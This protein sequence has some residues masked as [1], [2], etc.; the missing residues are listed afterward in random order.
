MHEPPDLGPPDHRSEF[1][2]AGLQAAARDA[3]AWS[4]RGFEKAVPLI[5]NCSYAPR[6]QF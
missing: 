3:A 6:W 5:D 1:L 4:G 2:A